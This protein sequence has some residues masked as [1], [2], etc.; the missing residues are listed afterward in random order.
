VITSDKSDKPPSDNSQL[1]KIQ[2]IRLLSEHEDNGIID[3]SCDFKDSLDTQAL[4][5]KEPN[6]VV[7]KEDAAV[8]DRSTDQPT[9]LSAAESSAPF[10]NFKLPESESPWLNK[11][12]DPFLDTQTPWLNKIKDPFKETPVSEKVAS[13]LNDSP[14]TTRKQMDNT[15]NT[16]SAA[17]KIFQ[18]L[19][20]KALQ[21]DLEVDTQ[22][23]PDFFNGTQSSSLQKTPNKSNV[24][25]NIDFGNDD[26]NEIELT[27][28]DIP[29][30]EFSTQ[31]I[32]DTLP[33]EVSNQNS[34]PQDL[35]SDHTQADI[36]VPG[37]APEADISQ[38]IIPNGDQ[39]TA[40]ITNDSNDDH[41]S[42]INS[43]DE[44]NFSLD[45]GRRL[46][47]EPA[48]GDY[49]NVLTED[50]IQKYHRDLS[51]KVGN[52]KDDSGPHS[53]SFAVDTQKISQG[54][55]LNSL[56]LNFNTDTIPLSKTSV[57]LYKTET[58]LKSSPNAQRLASS[59]P[60]KE[61][62][63]EAF[64]EPQE[65]ATEQTHSQ[66][67]FNALAENIT[68]EFSDVDDESKVDNTI[69][70]EAENTKV[71]TT[72]NRD[73]TKSSD[74]VI[75]SPR[76]GRASPQ[77][78]DGQTNLSSSPEKSFNQSDISAILDA[79]S[80][81]LKDANGDDDECENE[82][83]ISI[84]NQTAL[85]PDY[86]PAELPFQVLR[87][88]THK[89]TTS[90][91]AFKNSVWCLDNTRYYPGLILGL[92]NKGLEVKFYETTTEVNGGVYPLDIQIGDC[93][94]IGRLS[95]VVTG[96]EC[97]IQDSNE[98]IIRCM[99]GYDTVIVK[100]YKGKGKNKKLFDQEERFPL[101]EVRVENEEWH[102]RTRVLNEDYL[103]KPK[104]FAVSQISNLKRTIP[105][106]YQEE[107]VLSTP[108]KQKYNESDIFNECIFVITGDVNKDRLTKL[109][110]VNGGTVIE[111]GFASM[112]E[113][114][115]E[116]T[117]FSNKFK[118]YRFAALIAEKYLRSSKYLETVALGWPLLSQEFI[119]D[120][121]SENHFV[122]RIHPYLLPSGESSKL[123][124]VAKSADISLFVENW[125]LGYD[126]THQLQNNRIL[127][128]RNVFICSKKNI[129]ITEFLFQILG[130][131][132]VFAI[133]ITNY[134]NLIKAISEKSNG[135]RNLIY[136]DKI[137]VVK[138]ILDFKSSDER[139]GKKLR[140]GSM[141]S[142]VLTNK[143]NLQLE[144]VDWEWLAQCVISNHPW[145]SQHNW[146]NK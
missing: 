96:L 3:S 110:S 70:E 93:L 9:Q 88:E 39:D 106:S 125:K 113:F 25:E 128:D 30:Q 97:A 8:M 103:T 71:A 87:N 47:S 85:T 22:I 121:V 56:P 141:L 46:H 107:L 24:D 38:D 118:C 122:E 74:P 34:E 116:G 133:P 45:V 19:R 51:K 23:A 117:P 127:S 78:T 57:N 54:K 18:D 49:L 115:K 130:S 33:I 29:T 98:Q 89:L 61:N 68:Q 132:N 135:E 35:R 4:L 109:I 31:G 20:E 124:G 129:E 15:M 91:I 44:G 80:S 82:H 144:L 59:T 72:F 37:T 28:V 138:S 102:K 55:R 10:K 99:R 84:H 126:L 16:P 83:D 139:K 60:G 1:S 58:P 123:G 62:N 77:K 13:R 86:Q 137:S 40:E 21:G 11:V 50:S 140:K 142:E 111:D 69:E 92:G 131:R 7:I 105:I 114:S 36:Q 120:C 81:Q 108:K 90:D 27:K 32:Q 76:K 134:T 6:T 94:K 146:S 143:Q 17:H 145:K 75:K 41:S 5:E 48:N 67:E 43:D 100:R 12:Q 2:H 101:E 63:I 64:K 119:Y 26:T 104:R 42:P 136:H 79:E 14:Y 95:Y 53:K 73:E 52:L 112:I 65:N 66:V